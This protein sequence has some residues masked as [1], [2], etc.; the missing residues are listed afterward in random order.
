MLGRWL[1]EKR[2]ELTVLL[3]DV[4]ALDDARN[5]LT[6]ATDYHSRLS[7]LNQIESDA[8]RVVT[9]KMLEAEHFVVRT[10]LVSS[11]RDRVSKPA[12]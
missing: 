1:A 11:T 12:N 7:A 5:A 8:S 2:F 9:C 10:A 3:I 4:K 6:Y